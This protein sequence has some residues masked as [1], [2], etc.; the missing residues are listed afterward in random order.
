MQRRT[1]KNTFIP[2][3]NNKEL[4][5]DMIIQCLFRQVVKYKDLPPEIQNAVDEEMTW[6]TNKP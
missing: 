4:A 2:H 5:V 1:F 3:V 6:R